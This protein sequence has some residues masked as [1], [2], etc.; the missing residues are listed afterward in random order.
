M[1]ILFLAALLLSGCASS[2]AMGGRLGGE[3]QALD[4]NGVPVSGSRPITLRLEG[5]Q[6]SGNSGCN[7]Y[8]GPI[9]LRSREG[10]EFGPL[11]VTEM[12][13][14]P[15]AMEQESRYLSILRSVQGYSYYSDR[16]ISLIAA[17]GRAVRFRRPS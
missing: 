4:I 6:A 3:W 16:G 1:R 13:C 9:R 17:D 15:E 12:A 7:S 14:A 11:A 5:V 8:S 2:V 10:I